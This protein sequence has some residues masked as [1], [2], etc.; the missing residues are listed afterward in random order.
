M[1]LTITFIAMISHSITYILQII[2][3]LI[4]PRDKIFPVFAA[5]PVFPDLK[6]T[7]WEMGIWSNWWFELIFLLQTTCFIPYRVVS[8]C[9]KNVQNPKFSHVAFFAL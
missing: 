8:D 4:V 6:I 9:S 5:F 2:H 3:K 1:S 7:F